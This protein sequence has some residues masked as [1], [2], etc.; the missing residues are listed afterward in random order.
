MPGAPFLQGERVALRTVEDEDATFLR[1][2]SNDPRIRVPMTF[3]GPTNLEQQRD[4]MGNDG[5]GADFLITVSGAETG[6]NPEYVTED[7][8]PVEPIGYATLFHVN[9]G[10]GNGEIAYWLTPPAQGN[11]YMSEAAALLLDHAFTERRL[12]RVSA[13]ALESNDASRGLLESLGF[14]EEGLERD[15]KYVQGEYEDVYRYSLLAGE[16]G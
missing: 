4:H 12:H 11:G 7:D 14:L 5:D 16:W 6:Y 10:A 8:P 13:R 2:H 1:D 3:T 9:Q 15:A